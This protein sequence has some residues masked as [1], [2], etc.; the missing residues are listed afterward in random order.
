L[1]FLL[2]I[3]KLLPKEPCGDPR[4]YHNTINIGKVIGGE[5]TNQV[6]SSA[7][8]F[9]DIRYLD[10]SSRK[11]LLQSIKKIRKNFPQVK[12]KNIAFGK[13][14]KINLNRP[15]IELWRKI[16]QDKFNINTKPIFSHGSSDARFFNMKKTAVLLTRPKG[17]N[18]HSEEEWISRDALNKFYL[19]LKEWVIKV[20]L[21]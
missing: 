5:A 14:Y 11:K 13:S 20:A 19:V 15:E 9:V 16:L 18:L 10:D 4:H 7:E 1:N 6:A 12:I 3:K 17:G 2:E 21:N 8:A